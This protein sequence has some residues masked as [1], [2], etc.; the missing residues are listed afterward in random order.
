MGFMAPA[1]TATSTLRLMVGGVGLLADPVTAT[2][3]QALALLTGVFQA[4]T[5]RLAQEEVLQPF[6][7][8]GAFHS[9]RPPEEIPTA[10]AILI[11]GVGRLVGPVS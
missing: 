9:L 7:Q 10:V 11:P 2:I 3:H 5:V 1:A 8:W 4:E 6:R